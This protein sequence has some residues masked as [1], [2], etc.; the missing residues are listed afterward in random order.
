MQTE[1]SSA[2]R[3]FMGKPNF[4]MMMVPP[5]VSTLTLLLNSDPDFEREVQTDIKRRIREET[6]RRRNEDLMR[7]GRE[8]DTTGLNYRT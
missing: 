5:G 7:K 1:W 2:M 4:E 6:E 8:T 3:S